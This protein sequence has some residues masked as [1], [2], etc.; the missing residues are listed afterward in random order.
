MIR[1]TSAVSSKYFQLLFIASGPPFPHKDVHK[2]RADREET[3]HHDCGWEN[4]M[5][6]HDDAPSAR[7]V[8]KTRN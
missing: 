7:V 5:L 2:A 1:T 6:S 3:D 8:V 4:N